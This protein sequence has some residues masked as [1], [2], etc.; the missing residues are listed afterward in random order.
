[1]N[2]IRRRGWEIPESRLTP[3]HLAFSRRSLLVGAA[4]MIVLP[5]AANAQRISDLATLPDPTANL[6]PAKR[7]ETY[8]LDRPI[9]DEKIN[10]HYNN[11]YEFNSS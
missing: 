2:V 4:S 7:N 9:T 10:D 1:M 3:E 8:K 11:F 5:A 6:Y